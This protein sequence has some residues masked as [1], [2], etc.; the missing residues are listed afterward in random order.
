AAPGQQF[1]AMTLG[2]DDSIIVADSRRGL[3]V[4]RAGEVMTVLPRDALPRPFVAAIAQTTDG[5]IWLG[6][7]HSGLLRVRDGQ[8]TAM[9][10][11]SGAPITCLIADR[12]HGLWIGTDSGVLRWDAD[13]LTRV[14]SVDEAGGPRVL[15]MVQDRD[16]NVWVG[17]PDGLMRIG[18]Q[19]DVSIDR[20]ESSSAVTALFEDREGNLWVGDATGL[21]RWRDGVF[22]SYATVDD[23]AAGDI[24]PILSDGDNRLWFAPVSGGLYWLRDGHVGAIASLRNDVIY[25]ITGDTNAILVGRQRGGL[26]RIRPSGDTFTTETF[27]ERDGLAQNQVFAVH[28]AREGSVWA[29]T[30]SRGATR[31]KDGVFTTYTTADGLASNTVSAVLDAADG[32]VWFATPNGASAMSPAGWR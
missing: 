32:T 26:T 14:T 31:M 11:V 24:G 3:L 30:L 21:E 12:H 15:A 16:A 20:R 10:E 17:T 13:A 4:Q 22:S 1:G 5:D 29:G 7:R 18:A 19:G 23:I 6:T 9:T 27:T 25:S 28:R 8:I 2:H